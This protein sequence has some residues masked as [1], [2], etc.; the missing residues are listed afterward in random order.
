MDA[1]GSVLMLI[2]GVSM[3]LGLAIVLHPLPQIGL[4]KRRDGFFVFIAAAAVS[5][6]AHQ[7]SP[8]LQEEAHAREIASQQQREQ[9]AKEIAVIKLN[10][11]SAHKRAERMLVSFSLFN[12]NDRAIKDVRI[13]CHAGGSSGTRVNSLYKTLYERIPAKGS[14]NMRDF[15]M[16]EVDTAVSAVDCYVLLFEWA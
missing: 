8:S 7:I 11:F 10:G 6:L 15:P 3:L 4:A 1:I 2:A 16:G 14:F 9:R 12:G 13:A 5:A